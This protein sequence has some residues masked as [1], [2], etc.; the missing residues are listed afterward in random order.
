MNGQQV[1]GRTVSVSQANERPRRWRAWAAQQAGGA[2]PAAAVRAS[3]RLTAGQLSSPLPFFSSLSV[4]FG[5]LSLAFA[6]CQV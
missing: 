4:V 2:W 5:P 3:G 6:V 1:G